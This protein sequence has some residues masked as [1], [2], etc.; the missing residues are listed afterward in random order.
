[1][2][3]S[4][5]KFY[6]RIEAK[7]KNVELSLAKSIRASWRRQFSFP[8]KLLGGESMRTGPFRLKVHHT[9]SDSA[10]SRYFQTWLGNPSI[11]GL[12][13][14]GLREKNDFLLHRELTSAFPS[15]IPTPQCIGQQGV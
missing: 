9:S 1:M 13:N 3:K 12:R 8:V 10:E 7:G 15:S 5:G 11:L 4:Y 14:L 6:R 2:N